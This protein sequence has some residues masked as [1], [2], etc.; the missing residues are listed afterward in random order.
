MQHIDKAADFNVNR[1][2][3]QRRFYARKPKRIADVVAQV[4][5]A[6]GYGRGQSLED[7]AVAWR[8]A[9]GEA[10]ASFSRPGALKRGVLEVRVTTSTIVQELGFQKQQIL[11][12]LRAE[13]PD[14]KLRDLRFRVGAID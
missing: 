11:A 7:L 9:T 10:L 3:E 1:D 8:K 6:R 5:T 14:A 2:R 4:I 12:A 13:F